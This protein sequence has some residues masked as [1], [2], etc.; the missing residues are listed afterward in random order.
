M[1]FSS[2]LGSS[3]YVIQINL[4]HICIQL[5]VQ[6][7]L[8]HGHVVIQLFIQLLSRRNV[9]AVESGPA[10]P[11]IRPTDRHQTST[12]CAD[13]TSYFIAKTERR[14]SMKAFACT[15]S[16]RIT[17]VRGKYAWFSYNMKN[18]FLR[19]TSAIWQLF[20]AQ[21]CWA[22]Q[23]ILIKKSIYLH[24]LKRNGTETICLKCFHNQVNYC[25]LFWCSLNA[26]NIQKANGSTF[27]HVIEYVGNSKDIW[28]IF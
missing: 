14:L 26:M 25:N 4:S 17:S 6:M 3:H 27:I 15:A 22:Q 7:A 10:A 12:T 23:K 8:G 18:V 20:S 2:A 1:Q 21:S 16:N 19:E 9:V 28:H 11:W 5:C 24:H 13:K